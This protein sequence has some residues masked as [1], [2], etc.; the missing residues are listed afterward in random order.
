MFHLSF[1]KAVFP[2]PKQYAQWKEG[3]FMYE[4]GVI[5]TILGP[6]AQQ[7]QID[8]LPTK[9]NFRVI[10]PK[11]EAVAVVAGQQWTHLDRLQV[12]SDVFF[13]LPSIISLDRL[14]VSSDAFFK[15]PSIISLEIERKSMKKYMK[16][17]VQ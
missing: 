17:C 12:S 13:K 15:L 16:F 2:F 10:I 9:I 14:Q 6:H 3:C 1:K 7:V 4:P 8:R 11:S 5:P